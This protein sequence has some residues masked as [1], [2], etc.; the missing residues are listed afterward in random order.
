LRK[1]LKS[2]DG[3]VTIEI[4]VL[5][6]VFFMILVSVIEIGMLMTR[7]TMLGRGL[8][9]AVRDLRLDIPHRGTSMPSGGESVMPPPSFRIASA[10]CRWN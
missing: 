3:N 4:V 6:P 9:V 10:F 8:D 2:E 1:F 5:F 7:N